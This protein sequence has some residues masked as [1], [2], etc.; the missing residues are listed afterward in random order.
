MGMAGKNALAMV[1]AF[2]FQVAAVEEDS[3]DPRYVAELGHGEFGI[4]IVCYFAVFEGYRF[5]IRGVEDDAA[6]ECHPDF[7]ADLRCRCCS[8]LR[9]VHWCWRDDGNRWSDVVRDEPE[10]A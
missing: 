9:E 7:A 8:S 3:F 4:T 1:G 10:D 2:G 5:K 6:F